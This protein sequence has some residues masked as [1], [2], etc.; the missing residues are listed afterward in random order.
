MNLHSFFIPVFYYNALIMN[1]QHRIRVKV[2]AWLQKDDCLFVVKLHDKVK[3]DDYYRSIGGN[4]EFGETT[5]QALLR[6]VKEELGTG[7][8]VT[9]E[10][11]ISENLFICD[12][13]Q[14]HEI[15]YLYPSQFI[16]ESFSQHVHHPL[17]EAD[18]TLYEATWIELERFLNGELR[19]VPDSRLEWYRE[20]NS[21]DSQLPI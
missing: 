20:H 1:T 15:V 7:L 11:L 3:G 5:R 17:V 10:P 9:G 2:L 18:G 8:R 19:L 12:G 6:E 16:D 21:A 13:Q 4:V 14:G